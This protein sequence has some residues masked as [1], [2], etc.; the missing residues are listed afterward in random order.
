MSAAP[1]ASSSSLDAQVLDDL[2]L[3]V[4]D[5]VSHQYRAEIVASLSKLGIHVDKAALEAYSQTSPSR[6]RS[7][8]GGC[9]ALPGRSLSQRS[10]TGSPRRPQA[11]HV[12]LTGKIGAG[13]SSVNGMD[14]PHT[15]AGCGEGYGASL[16]LPALHDPAENVQHGHGRFRNYPEH[17]MPS[18]VFD[19]M[20]QPSGRK[21]RLPKKP[22][23]QIYQERV[24]PRQD[25]T[26]H[27]FSDSNN[28]VRS[29][30]SF[31]DTKT[32]KKFFLP[33]PPNRGV[34]HPPTLTD[35]CGVSVPTKTALVP[36]HRFS[37][38]PTMHTIDISPVE[39]PRTTLKSKIRETLLHTGKTVQSTEHRKLPT[40]GDRFEASYRG[41]FQKQPAAW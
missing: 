37:G 30:F 33:N 41:L 26:D 15:S 2:L 8:S 19:E 23:A 18:H 32:T 7:R 34:V 22:L 3:T 5:S 35:I 13:S 1:A 9:G 21:H 12:S 40:A 10:L 24:S 27:I 36:S 11:H 14:L 20:D 4:G 25:T 39:L 28:N 29:G 31:V 16:D 17:R 6:G 38:A